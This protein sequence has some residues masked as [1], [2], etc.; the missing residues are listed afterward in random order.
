[1]N[2][3]YAH[4]YLQIREHTLVSYLKPKNPSLKKERGR[5]GPVTDT[6]KVLYIYVVKKIS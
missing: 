6:L 1:M 3:N 5:E 4:P 2:L